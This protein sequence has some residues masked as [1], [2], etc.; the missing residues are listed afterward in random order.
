MIV[1]PVI[2][3]HLQGLSFPK[4]LEKIAALLVGEVTQSKLRELDPG[5]GREQLPDFEILDPKSL[6]RIG[7]MEVTT[8]T[9]SHRARFAAQVRQQD[10]QLPDLKWSWS[11]H[12]N[13][14]ANPR[15]LRQ[16]IGPILLAMEQA[17]VPQDWLPEYP[18]LIDP[19]EGALPSALVNLGVVAVC[20]WNQHSRPG[21]AWVSVQQRIPAGSF[22]S[23]RAL[24]DEIQAELNK[25][26]N[27]AKL[28]S[29]GGR[30]ELFVWLDIG[31]GAAAALTLC[32]PPWEE[33]LAT[34]ASPVLPTGVT[35]VWAG[36]G[37]ADWPRPAT[38][39]LR[40]NDAGW[41]SFG[42]PDLPWTLL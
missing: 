42:R 29:Q 38:C 27:L 2:P 17:G 13:N 36:T 24:T 33:T 6:A 10:W 40:F 30:A 22:S 11:I 41:Q 7:I 20:A 4:L 19:E 18:S 39:L 26:D 21:E 34:V 31:N 23:Q 8:T 16:E 28:C 1:E 12:V 3:S 35:A 9:R 5:G 25:P 14:A 32:T 37:M 15:Q